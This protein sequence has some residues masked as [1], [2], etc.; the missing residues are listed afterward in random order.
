MW[1]YNTRYDWYSFADWVIN[2]EDG[3]FKRRG[4]SGSFFFALQDVFSLPLSWSVFGLQ[5]VS[6]TF[7]YGMTFF[8][9]HKKH[10]SLH[11]LCL[12]ASP[13]TFLFVIHSFGAIGRKEIMVL[14][15][16]SLFIFWLQKARSLVFRSWRKHTFFCLSLSILTFFHELTLFYVPYFWFALW[17]IDRQN[18]KIKTVNLLIIGFGYWLAAAIP[19]FFFYFWGGKI[20]EG[21][22]F[23]ILA[24]RGVEVDSLAQG[25]LSWHEDFDTIIYIVENWRDFSRYIIPIFIGS[26]QGYFLLKTIVLDAKLR[27]KYY[28]FTAFCFVYS[29]PLFA[30]ALDWGRWIYIHFSL[31]LLII[32]AI[33]PQKKTIGE[34]EKISDLA[35]YT[36]Y[37]S[38]FAALFWCLDVCNIG[39]TYGGAIR[40]LLKCL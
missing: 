35:N 16:F 21:A 17:T 3:G 13:L 7:F 23:S 4:L 27:N 15:L 6:Y 31:L 22:T 24:A 19:V 30:L 11:L 33:L 36:A 10:I 25:V 14:A 2:Y 8:L 1:Q 39:F 28:K 18:S 20:N 34:T 9:L 32:I 26:I 5:A 40:L 12:I 29:L 37:F 38:L